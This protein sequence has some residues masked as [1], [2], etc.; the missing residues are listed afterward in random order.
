MI[1]IVVPKKVWHSWLVHAEEFAA[2]SSAGAL[3]QLV[4]KHSH[5]L[6]IDTVTQ[7]Q[8]NTRMKFYVS[9]RPTDW[10]DVINVF[11]LLVSYTIS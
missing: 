8:R 1:I 9:V 11:D 6:F 3:D 4:E 7:K 2:Q 5:A 10:P